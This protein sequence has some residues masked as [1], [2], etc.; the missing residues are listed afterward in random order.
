MSKQYNIKVTLPDGSEK[1][2]VFNAGRVVRIKAEAQ[3]LWD[4]TAT[5]QLGSAAPQVPT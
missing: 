5:C 3:L 4:S 1:T 2:N